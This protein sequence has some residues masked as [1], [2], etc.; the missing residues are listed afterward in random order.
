MRS[1]RFV[2]VTSNGVPRERPPA[3]FAA[4]CNRR[5]GHG[6]AGVASRAIQTAP[7]FDKYKKPTTTKNKNPTHPGNFSHRHAAKAHRFMSCG[8]G[9][10]GPPNEE[11]DTDMKFLPWLVRHP[12]RVIALTLL[13][14]T[15]AAAGLAHLQQTADYR[16]FFIPNDP[17][18]AAAEALQ[19]TYARSDN[20]LFVI[21]PKTGEVF[22]NPILADVQALT[23][24]AWQ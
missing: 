21:A 1:L 23:A 6:V 7:Y 15:V 16:I 10:V 3:R 2:A 9:T 12:R 11:R 13:L 14:V 18:L 5:P 17:H 19:A 4:Y 24:A 8:D 22:T 20:V